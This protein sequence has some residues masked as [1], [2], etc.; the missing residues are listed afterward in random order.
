MENRNLGPEAVAPAVR[1]NRALSQL[2][3]AIE[4]AAV[5]SLLAPLRELRKHSQGK[6]QKLKKSLS[7][8]GIVYPILIDNGRRIIAGHA[9]WLAAKESGF[10]EIPIIVIDHLTPDEVRVLSP[11]LNK[12]AED[13]PWDDAALKIELNELLSLDLDFS[14]D[15]RGAAQTQCGSERL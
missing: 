10:A 12:L 15:V 8:F 7:T 9:L 2:R 11:A 1:H 14:L 3:L 13:S 6:I 5:G 4:Y